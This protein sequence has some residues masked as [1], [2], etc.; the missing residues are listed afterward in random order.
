L[1][2]IAIIAILAAILFPV[3]ARARENAR[4]TSCLS[5]MKQIGIAIMQYTQEY[6]EKYP[7][8]QSRV[9]L[10]N[11]EWPKAIDPYLKSGNENYTAG[12]G[13]V[14]SCPSFPTGMD[15]NL[16]YAAHSS[17]MADKSYGP[18]NVDSATLAQISVPAQTILLA[19]RG[20][21]MYSWAWLQFDASRV[22]YQ[23]GNDLQY[24]RDEP[25]N[26][27]YAWPNGAVMPRYRHLNTGNMLFTDGHAKGMRR[28]L[29]SGDENWKK[30][31]CIAGLNDDGTACQ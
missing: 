26:D 2:V 23:D 10:Y 25:R 31:L 21:S 5:N 16:S 29:L 3:F 9:G 24:D 28:G 11:F 20:R 6:D 13:G 17:I 15:N 27:V 14:F 1:V 8:L 4:R 7:L 19:E 30:Y 12:S 22:P 18:A